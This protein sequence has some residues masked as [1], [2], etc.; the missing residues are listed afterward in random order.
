MD[1]WA[2]GRVLR[3][4]RQ[5]LPCPEREQGV[6]LIGPDPNHTYPGPFSA[7]HLRGSTDKQKASVTRSRYKS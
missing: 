6:H 3:G 5:F 1:A 2:L 4:V 7:N